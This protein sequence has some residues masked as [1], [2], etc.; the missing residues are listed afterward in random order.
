MPPESIEV[1]EIDTYNLQGVQSANIVQIV[2]TTNTPSAVSI[3]VFR[4]KEAETKKKETSLPNLN[5]SSY[6][7]L[8]IVDK[9][10]NEVKI[11]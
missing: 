5:S 2:A 1:K 7:T 4:M 11:G 8:L 10:G 3:I 9:D 6:P